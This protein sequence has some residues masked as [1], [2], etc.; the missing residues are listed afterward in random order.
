[1]PVTTLDA[2]T[3][4]IVID[5]QND[6]VA[7]AGADAVS[8]VVANAARLAEAFR[9]RG[10]PVVLVNVV[11]SAA[12]RRV[13][14]ARTAPVLPP[15]WADLV[16]E[17]NVQPTDHCVTKHTWGAFGGTGLDAWLKALGVTQVVMAGVSTSIGLDTTARQ[18][19]EAGFNI[20]FATDA[21]ADLNADAHAHCMTRIFPRIGETGTTQDIVDLLQRTA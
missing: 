11:P 14:Q 10:L 9:H 8:A 13:E 21:M 18:A 4:L 7:L 16:A 20:A 12:P 15:G 17:M 5:L 2:K 6:I 19:F 1:M 3:A